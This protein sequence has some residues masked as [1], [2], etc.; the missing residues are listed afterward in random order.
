LSKRGTQLKRI[1]AHC[2]VTPNKIEKVN[3]SVNKYGFDVALKLAQEWRKSKIK[4]AE[5]AGFPYSET[6]GT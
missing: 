5:T 3:F 2:S 4:E 6:H 1:N